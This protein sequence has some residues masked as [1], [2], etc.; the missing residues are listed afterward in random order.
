MYSWVTENTGIQVI[1]RCKEYRDTRNTE[2]QRIQGYR[3]Y[4]DSYIEHS[5]RENTEGYRE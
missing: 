4:R 1:Q 2:I 3:E 5:D